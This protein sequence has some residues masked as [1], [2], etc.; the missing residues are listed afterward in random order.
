MNDDFSWLD[1]AIIH[2]S[3]CVGVDRIHAISAN[4]AYACITISVLRGDEIYPDK[5]IQYCP[6]IKDLDLAASLIRGALINDKSLYPK[7]SI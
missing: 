1:D 5:I 4:P 6:P 2:I 3:K 7:N